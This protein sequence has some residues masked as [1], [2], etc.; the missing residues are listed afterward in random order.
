MAAANEKYNSL[1]EIMHLAARL[2]QKTLP[3]VL[4]GR[5]R[6]RDAARPAGAGA[7]HPAFRRARATVP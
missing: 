1:L 7:A 2:R 4:L 5:L 3:E 6:S